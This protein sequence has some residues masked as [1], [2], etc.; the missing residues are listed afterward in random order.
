MSKNWEPTRTL[1][2]NRLGHILVWNDCN[3]VSEILIEDE[4]FAWKIRQDGVWMLWRDVPKPS[5]K[6]VAEA[7]KLKDGT[8]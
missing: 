6:Q 4:G 5:P 7:Q 8:A 2:D 1:P 3:G